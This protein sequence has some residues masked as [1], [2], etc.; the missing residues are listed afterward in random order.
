[1]RRVSVVGYLHQT[2]ARAHAHNQWVSLL[3]G[4]LFA[5]PPLGECSFLHLCCCFERMRRY[6]KGGGFQPAARKKGKALEIKD[7]NDAWNDESKFTAIGR[8]HEMVARPPCMVR[9]FSFRGRDHRHRGSLPLPSHSPFRRPSQRGPGRQRRISI[10]GGRGRRRTMKLPL[11]G[12]WDLGS[13]VWRGR[14]IERWGGRGGYGLGF[15]GS[16]CG[17]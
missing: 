14:G 2:R 8:N 10:R 6:R 16:G 17:V 11:F 12:V 4:S 3:L 1:M 13:W 5:A 9:H 15:G 7:L